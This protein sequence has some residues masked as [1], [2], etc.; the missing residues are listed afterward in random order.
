M[1]ATPAIDLAFLLYV[2]ADTDSRD[3][4]RGELLSIY[5][6]EFKDVLQKL[7]YLRRIPTLNDIQLEL[8]KH[9]VMGE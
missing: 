5:H 9:S 3:N 8:L 6:E 7:G 2:V 1:W 4:H